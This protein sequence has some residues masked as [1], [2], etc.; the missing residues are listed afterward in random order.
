MRQSLNAYA[1]LCKLDWCTMHAKT[2]LP[3][4]IMS[5]LS[6]IQARIEAI[7][8]NSALHET[9]QFRE[10]TDVLDAMEQI[11]DT[12]AVLAAAHPR[13]AHV[14]ALRARAIM[15]HTILENKNAQFFGHLRTQIAAG[16][17]DHNALLQ[18]FLRHSSPHQNNDFV[19]DSLDVLVNGIVRAGSPPEV[20]MALEAEMVGYQPTPARLIVELVQRA[21]LDRTDV[22]YD[23]G[24]GLGQVAIVAALLSGAHAVGIEIDAGSCAYAR[25]CAAMLGLDQVAFR[26]EDARTATFLDGTVFYLYTPFHGTILQTV[27]DRLR[28]EANQRPIRICAYGSCTETVGQ[29]PWLTLMNHDFLPHSAITVFHSSAH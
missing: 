23:I 8:Q 6:S 9:A 18:T 12:I 19:Y 24:S 2:S 20:P 22:F 15:L 16:N 21:Q 14:S 28:N 4:S 11:L 29:Q 1:L 5:F 10:R 17:Q 27:L 25:R 7:E 26:N 3:R 13:D